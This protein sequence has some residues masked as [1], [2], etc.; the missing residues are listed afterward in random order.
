MSQEEKELAELNTL[1]EE[2]ENRGRTIPLSVHYDEMS[3]LGEVTANHILSIEERA[4]RLLMYLVVAV[5][6]GAV[7]TALWVKTR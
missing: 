5:A 6:Y 7:M 3:R 2:I 4:D 1:C